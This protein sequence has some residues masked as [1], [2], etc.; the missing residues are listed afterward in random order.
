M[1][2]AC[3]C[4][5]VCLDLQ[6]HLQAMG[7]AGHDGVTQVP[8]S[9]LVTR[10]PPSPPGTRLVTLV[11]SFGCA[12]ARAAGVPAGAAAP[13]GAHVPSVDAH[14]PSVD[15]HVPSVDAP[16]R[17]YTQVCLQEVPRSLDHNAQRTFFLWHV[18]WPAVL[19]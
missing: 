19:R 17:Q 3:L 13:Y 5:S 1:Q 14:V 8:G 10:H 9:R 11:L 15:A 18:D 7:A 4:L 2:D 6:M 12:D 16:V